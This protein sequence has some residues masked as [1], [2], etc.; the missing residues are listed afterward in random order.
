MLARIGDNLPFVGDPL[1]NVYIKEPLQPAQACVIWMHG[2][3]ADAQDMAGL[4]EQLPLNIAVRHV[5][6][7]APV[8][9]V[10]V[11]NSMKMRAWY[12]I[13][14]FDLSD[15]EDKVGVADSE[16]IIRKVITA[17][18][19]DGFTS[20]QIF[21]AGFSQGGAMALY[22]GLRNSMPLAGVISLSAYLPLAAELYPE[23]ARNT[24]F[25]I[26][27]GQQDDV[28]SPLWTKQSVNWLH[29]RSYRQI[30]FHEYP[31]AHSICLPEIQDLGQ[32]LTTQ[33]STLTAS[34]GDK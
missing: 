31:M 18:L 4:A 21:L 2:L 26:A 10:T 9:A 20:K 23:L 16:T 14:G 30:S 3:G 24:P 11:N 5:F 25:F 7:D 22:V 15:R 19:D 1:L 29:A 27:A 34:Q 17:Q 6:I 33:I 8:R 13:S 28:V 32:W 12:D